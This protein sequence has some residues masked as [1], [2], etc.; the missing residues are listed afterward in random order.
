MRSQNAQDILCIKYLSGLTFQNTAP[1][2]NFLSLCL[3]SDQ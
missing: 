3:K 1:F 2:F